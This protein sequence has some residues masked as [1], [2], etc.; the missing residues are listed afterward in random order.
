MELPPSEAARLTAQA[1][2]VAQ[3][4]PDPRTKVGCLLVGPALAVVA[5]GRNDFPAGIAHGPRRWEA[6][7]KYDRVIHAEAA[8]VADAARR[9]APTAGCLA[10]VTKFPC[11]ACVRLLLQSGV[12]GL[13]APRPDGDPR[14]AREYAVALA[15]LQ[16]AQVSVCWS[17][18]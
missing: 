2:L 16:E 4:S 15:L 5:T 7:G 17:T 14:W 10:V 13:V 9:G 12:R 8:A 3:H 18:V 6:P 1:E 11:G